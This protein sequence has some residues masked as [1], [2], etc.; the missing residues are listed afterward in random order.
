MV[1]KRIRKAV[2][3]GVKTNIYKK[4]GSSKEY[5][6]YKGRHVSLSKYKKI[7]ANK[8]KQSGGKCPK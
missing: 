2:I 8:A 4:E 1:Y 7:K 3:T 6:S 5:V